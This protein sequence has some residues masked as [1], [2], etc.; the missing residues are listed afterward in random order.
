MLGSHLTA[1][2]VLGPNPGGGVRF[3]GI[4][5]ELEAVLAALT[6]IGT[7]A[8]LEARAP[9]ERRSAALWFVGVAVVVAA[10]LAPGRFGADVG[11]AI[12]LAV[13]AATAAALA[14]G[15]G[16]RRA[17]LVVVGGGALALAALFAVDLVLGGAL[18]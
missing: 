5:N 11:A 8:F 12:V 15:L 18:I 3:F 6:L 4:G 7:G 16:P 1:F 14:L 17:A 10:A 2:S 9:V 13:G